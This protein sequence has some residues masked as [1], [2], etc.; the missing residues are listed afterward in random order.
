M[1]KYIRDSEEII[2]LQEQNEEL[3]AKLKKAYDTH[4]RIY[5]DLH[6]LMFDLKQDIDL[7]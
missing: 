7:Q 2:K 1:I 6:L 3:K 4:K 5:D